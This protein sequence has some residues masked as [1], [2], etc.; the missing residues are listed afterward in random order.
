MKIWLNNRK[1]KKL[2]FS[3]PCYNCVFNTNVPYDGHLDNCLLRVLNV[4]NGHDWCF[5]GYAYENM[6]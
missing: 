3:I 1:V 5:S 6:A 4:R 2:E